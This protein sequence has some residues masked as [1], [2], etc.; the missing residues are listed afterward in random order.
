MGPHVKFV[1]Q[2]MYCLPCAPRKETYVG[3]SRRIHRVHHHCRSLRARD[4]PVNL[5]HVVL[6][7][8]VTEQK[9]AS[10]HMPAANTARWACLTTHADRQELLC[11]QYDLNESSPLHT[12]R[13]GTVHVPYRAKYLPKPRRAQETNRS[14]LS[15]LNALTRRAHAPL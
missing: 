10:S 1:P 3:C 8:P 6:K 11:L 9:I 13:R 12:G 7:P 15:L 2:L 4:L 5:T 14:Y